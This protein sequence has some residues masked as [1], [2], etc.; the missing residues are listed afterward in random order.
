MSRP[1]IGAV[2][3][4]WALEGGRISIEGDSFDV[5]G[6]VVPQV[7]VGGRPARLVYAS[8]Q[9]LTVIVPSG[10]EGGRT[11]V[12][13]DGIPGETA[14]V[15]VGVP[16]ATD[17]HQVDNPV[18]DRHGHLLVTFSGTRGQP[19]PVSIFRIRPDGVR[20]AFVS[21]I[22]NPTSMSLDPAGRLHVSSRFEGTI[23]RVLD[24]GRTEVA[25][26][27][28]GVPCGLAFDEDGTMFVGDR[29]G[30]VFRIPPGGNPQTLCTLPP[31]V[32]AFHLALGPDR[33][34]YVTAPTLASCDSIYRVDEQG[35]VT[36]V[37]SRFGRPQGLAF[38]HAGALY[39]AEA[40]AGSSGLYRIRPSGAELVLSAPGLVGLAFDPA[41]GLA[42]ATSDTVYRFAAAAQALQPGD[43]AG[44][45]D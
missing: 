9:R 37:S 17:L 44:E 1:R 27:D 28:L 16:M 11:P 29:S 38:D 32:A 43:R 24:N 41:G 5:G 30:T 20:E 33:A 39:V 19:A 22:L 45:G 36:V 42:V 3:P 26:T 25:A 23:Y 40:L 4:L 10:L 18:F 13:V 31:S 15:D 21:G 2:H 7:R 6:A 8:P 12:R 34:L 14:F 35:T